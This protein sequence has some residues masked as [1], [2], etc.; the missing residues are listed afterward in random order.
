VLRVHDVADL[1]EG[2]AAK[3]K[4]LHEKVA[5][6]GRW[7]GGTVEPDGVRAIVVFAPP[8]V[9]ELVE[10]ILR[11][12]RQPLRVVVF[13]VRDLEAQHP[14]YLEELRLRLGDEQGWTL[15]PKGGALVAKAST[16]DLETI[17]AHLRELRTRR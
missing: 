15:E 8:R 1:V 11:Q 6:F 16:Q 3:M 17:D 7:P 5:V 14:G 4:R 13:D 9:Q 10:E 2:D 12:E